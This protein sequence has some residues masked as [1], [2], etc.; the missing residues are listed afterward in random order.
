MENMNR[1]AIVF[2]NESVIAAMLQLPE[3]HYVRGVAPDFFRGGIAV[4][5]CG[6]SLDEVEPSC[7]PPTL[8]VKA[9]LIN[10][11]ATAAVLGVRLE[12][13]DVRFSG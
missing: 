4:V 6:P 8:P 9:H 5:I 1:K 3:G 7:E 12:V 2:L 13:D 10:N 11:N